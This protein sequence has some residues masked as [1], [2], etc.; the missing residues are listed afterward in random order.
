MEF[1]FR[2]VDHIVNLLA[3]IIEVPGWFWTVIVVLFV[4]YQIDRRLESIWKVMYDLP[5]RLERS[6]KL[7][8]VQ[9]EAG[10][11]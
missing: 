9:F 6:R 10:R 11:K 2:M 4:G 5:D 8:D 1:V 3:R 7:E